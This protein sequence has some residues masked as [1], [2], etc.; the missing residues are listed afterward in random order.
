MRDLVNLKGKYSVF[1]FGSVGHR[2]R[3]HRRT[4]EV[5]GPG[6]A[7]EAWALATVCAGCNARLAHPGMRLRCA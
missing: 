6:V 2:T 3:G 4:Q 1:R 5:W 7:A